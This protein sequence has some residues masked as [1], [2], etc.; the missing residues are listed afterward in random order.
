M[1]AQKFDVAF[2]VNRPIGRVL[3]GCAPKSFL[4]APGLGVGVDTA[5][6]IGKVTIFK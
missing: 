2:G 5:G 4:D 1:V 3:S 6:L